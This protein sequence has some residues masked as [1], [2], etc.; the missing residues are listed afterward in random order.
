MPKI[1]KNLRE[2]L[3]E[4]ARRQVFEKGY[5]S[6]TIRSVAS[7]CNV[8]VGTVYNYFESKEMLVASFM[9]K[10]WTIKLDTMQKLPSDDPKKL[11]Y[12]I[13]DSI[14]TF[15]RDNEK[16]F[17][18][19]EA[20]KL[21]ST[22]SASRHKLLRSQISGFIRPVCNDLFT[23]EFIAESIIC[24]SMEDKAFGSVYDIIEKIIKK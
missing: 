10:D 18:D 14:R 5:A 15:A 4:E 11:L 16:L 9:L 22:G 7:A 2:Q 21:I 6:T 23:A 19:K 24:W 3:L 12:G 13:Y 20:A 1:I 17:S 8:G